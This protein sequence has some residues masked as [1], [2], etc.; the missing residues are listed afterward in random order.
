[1]TP[2]RY[3]S[4]AAFVAHW[5]ALVS[6][7]RADALSNADADRLEAMEKN[8]GA[9]TPAEREAIAC[10]PPPTTGEAARC[11]QRAELKVH[12]I[13]ANSDWLES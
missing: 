5:R 7:R 6:A 1:M 4:V 8:I 11:Y 10:D 3:S 13:L 2:R 12:R 9:L